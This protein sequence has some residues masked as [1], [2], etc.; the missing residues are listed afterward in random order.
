MNETDRELLKLAAKAAG[1]TGFIYEWIDG[2]IFIVP[3]D[4]DDSTSDPIEYDWLKD[5]GDAF[6]L[7]VKLGIYVSNSVAEVWRDGKQ[8]TYIF[9]DGDEPCADTRRAIVRAAAEIG[10]AMP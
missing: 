9:E 8:F 7:A 6:R 5:D 10:K 3:A 4:P 2:P 1:L